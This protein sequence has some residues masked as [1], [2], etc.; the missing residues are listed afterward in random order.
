MY[1]TAA[2]YY[3]W[4]ADE[5]YKKGHF[6]E[7]IGKYNYAIKLFPEHYKANYNL[8]N[9]YVT[10]EDYNNAV[11]CYEKALIAN[12]YYLNAR[13]NLGIVLSQQ[14]LDIDRAIVEYNKAINTNPFILN[15]PFVFNNK[16]S[17]T[18]SKAIAYYNLGIAYKNKSL[19]Y[20][21]DSME[22][23]DYLKQAAECYRNS[24]K[25]EPDSYESHYNLALTMQLLGVY[26][27][28]LEEYCKSINL[29]PLDYKAHYNLAILL[30]QKFLY[31]ESIKELEKAGLLL[32]VKG[33]Y[34]KT[35]YIYQILNEVSQRVIA[36]RAI[37]YEY[38]TEKSGE[39]PARS[40]DITYVN[41][42]VV[43]TEDLDKAITENMR[44]CSVCKNLPSSK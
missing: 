5:E 1:H 32:D 9:I 42:R 18:H 17:I 41:G 44:T 27:E 2:F 35:A 26:L 11:S 34:F 29:E 13:I 38:E 4:Q 36:K 3:V 19:L 8:G 6:Q 22:A 16:P 15:L 25:I 33:D 30:R 24:I 20:K 21:S 40:Y 37:S 31:R 14:I 43:P 10:Y 39:S 12:P 28:S 7:A 23:R